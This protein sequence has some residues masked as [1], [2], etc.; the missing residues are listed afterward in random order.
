ML[1]TVVVVITC[2]SGLVVGMLIGRVWVE[3]FSLVAEVTT[4]TEGIDSLG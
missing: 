3:G 2:A 4:A 1:A